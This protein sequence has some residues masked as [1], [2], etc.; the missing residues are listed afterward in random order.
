MPAL[1]VLYPDGFWLQQDN[2]RPHIARETKLWME[3]N[4]L[5]VMKWPAVS[6]DLDVIE[7]VWGLMKKRIDKT[8]NKTVLE[9]KREIEKI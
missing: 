7:N 1:Q 3:K 8:E 5:K 9:W 4:G 6:P 2:A